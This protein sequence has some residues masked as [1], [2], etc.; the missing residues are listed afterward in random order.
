M[1]GKAH[2]V[3]SRQAELSRK[4]RR[5]RGR[6]QVAESTQAAPDTTAQ[7]AT[8]VA[9]PESEARPTEPQPQPQPI[10]AQRAPEAPQPVRRA[11]RRVTAE[12]ASSVNF[13]GAELRYIGVIAALMVAILVALS[14]VLR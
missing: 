14:F 7:A 8:T 9:E 3:A 11:R 10:Q 2:R 12:Q 5:A 13:V 6:P 1:S 4:K